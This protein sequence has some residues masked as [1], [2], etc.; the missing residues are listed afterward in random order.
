MT[1]TMKKLIYIILL[2]VPML[3]FGQTTTENYVKN[4]T[5]LQPTQDGT[6]ANKDDKVETVTYYDGLGRP[7]QQVNARSGGNGYDIIIPFVY[8]DLGRQVKEYL[9]YVN[10]GQGIGTSSLHYQPNDGIIN[11]G[12]PTYYNSKFPDDF[13]GTT[14]NPYSEK[15]FENSPLNKVLK[16]GAPGKDWLLSTTSDDDHAIKMHYQANSASDNVKLFDVSHPA[17]DTESISL[18]DVGL[19]PAGELYKS[20]IKDENWTD[21]DAPNHTTEEFKNQ[22]GQVVL[23]R[24]YNESIPH[25]TYYIYDDFGNLTYVLPP[26]VNTA[27]GVSTTELSELCYQYKYDHRN[28][29]IEK[30]IPGKGWE[31]I[32]YDKLDRPVL[33]QDANQRTANEWLFT[34]Y[35]AFS[36][37]AYTGIYTTTDGIEDIKENISEANLYE[38]RTTIANTIA[39][40]TIYY[41][42]NV[43]PEADEAVEIL[44]INYYDDYNWN[45]GDSFDDSYDF[46][47][48]P[49]ISDSGSGTLTK[50]TGSSWV[51]FVSD[52]QILGDGF[53]E[54]TATQT[55]KR[56]MVGL[57]AHDIAADDHYDM[58]NYAIYIGY[59]TASRVYIYQSGTPIPIP[60]T[61]FSVGDTFKV[62]RSGHQILYKKNEV[63]FYTAEASNVP[64]VAD[65]SLL[66]AGITLTNVH[67]GYAAFGA[68]F[69]T[70]T[71][72]LPTGS[73]VRVLETEKWIT[74][75]SYYDDK[76][77][78]VYATSNNEY[79]V[80]KD[81]IS[82]QL[83]FT[84]KV[85]TTKSIH[86]KGT[87]VPIVTND[88]FTYDHIG[89]VLRQVQTIDG[90]APQLIAKNNYDELGQLTQKQV[91]GALPTIST[92]TNL[93]GISVSANLISKIGTESGWNA[94][95]ITQDAITG[96]GY[97]SFTALQ[98][99]KAIMV[100]LNNTASTS[101][102]HVD[103]E[104]TMYLKSD[105]V[106]RIYENSNN[107]GDKITYSSGDVLAIERRGMQIYY[108]K[109]GEVFYTSEV[110]ATATEY[111]GDISIWG[112]DA[113]PQLKDLV[114]V[115][116]E[117]ELQEVD[118]TYNVRGWLKEINEVGNLGNDL[119]SF[120][121]QYN[122]IADDS[123]KLFNG[124]IS[125]TFWQTQN[126]D[127]SIKNY[128]YTYDALNRIKTA[129]DNTGNYNLHNVNYD[130]NGNITFLKREGHI[131]ASATSF[132]IMDELTYGYDN[133]NKLIH[134]T[135]TGN[136]DFGFKDDP[137]T[138][139][140]TNDYAYDING[141][142][143]SDKNKNILEITYNHLNLPTRVEFGNGYIEY[144]YDAVGIKLKKTITNEDEMSITKTEYAGNFIYKDNTLEFFSHPEGYI[145]PTVTLSGVEADYVFQYADHLG[146]IRLAYQDSNND[147]VIDAT[148]EIKEENNYY[149]FGL[150]HKG[151]NNIVSGTSNTYQTYNG[152]ELEESLGFNIYEMDMRQFD[153]AIARWTVIDPVT[154]HNFSPYNGYDNNPI[155]WADPS[156]ADAYNGGIVRGT[157]DLQTSVANGFGNSENSEPP[158]NGLEW[159]ADDSG[160]YFWNNE[161]GS[162]EHYDDPNGTGTYSFQGYYNAEEFS[163]PVGDYSIIFDLSGI[164]LDDQYSS[165]HTIWSLA[166]PLL[167]YLENMEAITFGEVK[168]ISNQEK[169]PGVRIYSSEYMNGAITLG[170]MIITNPRMEDTRTLDHEY[171]HYLDFKHHFNYDKDAYL[172]KIGVPSFISA[173]G[174]GNHAKTS[175]EKRANRLGGEWS[176]NFILKNLYKTKFLK[177]KPHTFPFVLPTF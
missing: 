137:S 117:K 97:I 40:T 83:D 168:D 171:G 34:K 105:G 123:K 80:A 136:I 118:Y 154:H 11:G 35:D 43:Y 33:T 44:T 155:F 49:V 29:L 19:Y 21:D 64:L 138:G 46:T 5:Y 81:A 141:N 121:L 28:R 13:D 53:V 101:T 112:Y 7:K 23:K 52:T 98:T 50:T 176:N 38:S 17:G 27:D 20:I 151:Y 10:P 119:F 66:D 169:Y 140:G 14:I 71:K 25:D 150:K 48:N 88:N 99:N 91:G 160:Q 104:Y 159:F 158:V 102:N 59:G 61:T 135:D 157:G 172:A 152:K 86:T 156:G 6:V 153:P 94:G 109:N 89:R 32:L 74:T 85:L 166:G 76:G 54:F 26:K 124:N 67:V 147:G 177:H 79:L 37:V 149:P 126:V 144:V 115:D 165:L 161:Q 127:N 95:L 90:N 36:R 107:R 78:A 82:S 145:E 41:S 111:Y 63:I 2:V 122:D 22:Q 148:T 129:V 132:G 114:I 12:L 45:T 96:D 92:Y 170:N 56:V 31:Y 103:I 106:V 174:D 108:L 3:V 113:N 77:Q 110:L 120:G 84:G 24:T 70:A 65:G 1:K 73:K 146:N 9:P 57:S 16:Q 93:D 173:A 131:D 30:K 42:G 128:V 55:D 69:S 72:G 87:A 4:T 134:V 167:A 58:I 68:D 15:Q 39:G 175:T 125:S 164:K 116:L 75:V 163:E 139:S 8:D 51:G 162:Y 18:T 133:G 60:L 143:I 142:M 47:V 62:E 100:G 130:K